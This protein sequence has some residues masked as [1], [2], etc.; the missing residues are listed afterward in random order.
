MLTAAWNS[1][2]AASLPRFEEPPDLMI[3]LGVHVIRLE[4]RAEIWP[5]LSRAKG[6]EGV[7]EVISVFIEEA[8]VSGEDLYRKRVEELELGEGWEGH[9]D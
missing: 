7:V 9:R 6:L 4:N 8:E 1:L 5:T 3:W 2:T